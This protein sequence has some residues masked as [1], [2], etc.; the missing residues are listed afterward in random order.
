[1][2]N[3]EYNRTRRFIIVGSTIAAIFLI[4]VPLFIT[5]VHKI[6]QYE[7]G[8]VLT[9]GKVTRVA[10]RGITFTVPIIQKMVVVNIE[11]INRETFGYRDTA[12]D[13]DIRSESYKITKD[14]KIVNVFY[15]V[16][17][18]IIDPVAWVMN[19]PIHEENRITVIRDIMESNMSNVINSMNVDDIM[20]IGKEQIQ[21]QARLIMQNMFD[22]VKFGIHIDKIVIQETETP[23]AEVNEAFRA[24]NS[25]LNERD[26]K[27]LVAKR[28]A[29]KI[30]TQTEGNVARILNNAQSVAD[31]KLYLVKGECDRIRAMA[32]QYNKNPNLTKKILYLDM[33]KQ[34]LAKYGDNIVFVEENSNLNVLQLNSFLNSANN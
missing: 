28:E 15:V 24:V 5:S 26:T 21:D 22:N 8:V 18:K 19:P 6:E 25:A 11:E 9:W 10:D 3:N 33:I 30:V 17:Y 4:L 31:S 13:E 27:I 20:T 2:S 34:F 14:G 16:Q 29:S 32:A 12:E 7:K 1:M 23:N